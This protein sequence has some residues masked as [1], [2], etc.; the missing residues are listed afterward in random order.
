MKTFE[1]LNEAVEAVLET[2]KNDYARWGKIGTEEST[3]IRDRMYE[4]YCEGLT[5]EEGNKYIKL[6]GNGSVKGFICKTDNP[7]KGFV[8]GDMLMAK[9]YKAPATNF[10][11]GNCLLGEFDRVRWTGIL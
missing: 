2:M 9:S 5:F 10:A 7:K 4:E 3:D 11:R 8:T 1:N 6:I